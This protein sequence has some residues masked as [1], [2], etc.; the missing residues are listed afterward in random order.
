VVHKLSAPHS[1]G[2]SVVDDALTAGGVVVPGR[3][4]AVG[5]VG[6]PPPAALELGHVLSENVSRPQGRNQVV[7]LSLALGGRV[8]GF[9]DT[10][11]LEP[12]QNTLPTLLSLHGP[13]FHLNT[14]K[15]FLSGFSL[16][17]LKK[18]NIISEHKFYIL[19]G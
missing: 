4:V 16:F 5:A 9:G 7:K 19:L 10:V 17:N 8:V 11:R 13:L 18:R 15:Q 14:N 2:K 12:T 1:L 6:Q 3:R